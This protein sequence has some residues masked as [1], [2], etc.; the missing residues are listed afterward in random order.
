MTSMCGAKCCGCI[1]T[2]ATLQWH[3]RQLQRWQSEGK[4]TVTQLPP[5]QKTLCAQMCL[6]YSI[7]LLL[8]GWIKAGAGMM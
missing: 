8:L 3:S 4:S 2:T 1:L 6:L 7:S 5:A